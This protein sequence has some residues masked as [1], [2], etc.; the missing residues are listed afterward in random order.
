MTSELFAQ[1]VVAILFWG[2]YFVGLWG[3]FVKSGKPGWWALIPVVNWVLMLH[4]LNI[5]KRYAWCLLLL[6]SVPIGLIPIFWWHMCMVRA[7]GFRKLFFLLL[8]I[9][10]PIALLIAAYSKREYDYVGMLMM[11]QRVA[12]TWANAFRGFFLYEVAKRPS[13]SRYWFITR[14]MGGNKR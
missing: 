1:C 12:A 10:P 7:C 5:K 14:G 2:L 6:I 8:F 9:A 4:T 13:W 11:K 3:C